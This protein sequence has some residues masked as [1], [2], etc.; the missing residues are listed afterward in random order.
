MLGLDE[1]EALGD[2]LGLADGDELWPE[3]GLADGEALGAPRLRELRALRADHKVAVHARGASRAR[4]RK[5]RI[6]P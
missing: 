2:A 4:N 5:R 6:L 3:L 1:G